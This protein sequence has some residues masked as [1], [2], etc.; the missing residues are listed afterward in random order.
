MARSPNVTYPTVLVLQAIDL[1][2]CYGF[3]IMDITGLPSG[4][5][6][7]A[8]RRL[9]QTSLLRSRWEDEQRA[10]AE[11]RP[12]RRYYVITRAGHA[13]LEKGLQRF[14]GL[15]RV[16]PVPGANVVKP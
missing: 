1:G 15:E 11:Q 5:V 3:D 9:E 13:L 8:L 10:S 14:P 12:P 4:T 6:Y 16:I 7:P 2:Y